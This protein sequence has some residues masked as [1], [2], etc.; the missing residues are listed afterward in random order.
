MTK[1]A[2][3]ACYALTL[4]FGLAPC[5]A[6][7]TVPVPTSAATPDA[8]PTVDE[9]IAANLAT[10]GGRDTWMA[11]ESIKMSGVANGPG[12]TLDF[13]VYARRPNLARQELTLAVPGQAS[14]TMVSLFDGAKTWNIDPVMGTGQPTELT[15]PDADAARDQADFDSSLY[16]Y[17]ARGYTV[18]LLPPVTVATKQ[19]Y[20]LRVLRKDLPTQHYYLDPVTFVELKITTEGINASD[21]ELDDYQDVEGILVA[22]RIKIMRSGTLQ[23]E[24][25]VKT[26]EFNLPLD[27]ALFRVK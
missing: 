11:V 24:L 17:Q 25:A 18:E 14:R 27:D 2:I 1:P 21:A 13:V 7:Q 26:V 20:H 23:V 19:A 4:I 15:G 8:V 22:H 3:V 12:L 9:L 5:A 10:K 16:D 6:A